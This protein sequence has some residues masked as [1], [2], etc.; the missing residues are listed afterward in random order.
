[1]KGCVMVTI[2]ESAYTNIFMGKFEKLHIYLY[3][4]N[5]PTFYCQVIGNIYFLWSRNKSEPIKIID[6][7]NKTHPTIKFEFTYSIPTLLS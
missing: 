4:R 3:L 1:M 5:F 7:L 2:C 6:N